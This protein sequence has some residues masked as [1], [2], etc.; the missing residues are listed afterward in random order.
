MWV[1]FYAPR[2]HYTHLDKNVLGVVD[3]KDILT[4]QSQVASTV[5]KVSH[6]LLDNTGH[7]QAFVGNEYYAKR[8]VSMTQYIDI[9]VQLEQKKP[10]TLKASLFRDEEQQNPYNIAR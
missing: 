10:E 1:I 7:L 8:Y 9:P 5:G 6:D 3:D 4:F 2:N